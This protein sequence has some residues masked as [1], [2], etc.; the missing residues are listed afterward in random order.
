MTLAGFRPGSR[1][2]FLSGKGLGVFQGVGASLAIM[3][4]LNRDHL[5]WSG[6][7]VSH[8]CFPG[9]GWL[10]SKKGIGAFLISFCA[11]SRLGITNNNHLDTKIG[12]TS[13]TRSTYQRVLNGKTREWIPDN[14]CREYRMIHDVSCSLPS[15]SILAISYPCCTVHK[16]LLFFKDGRKPKNLI[17]VVQGGAAKE[18]RAKP[19]NKL[20]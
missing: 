16:K 7:G 19:K 18:Q 9:Q 3:H 1:V 20:T 14:N 12:S 8:V 6:H 4:F 5:S 13:A 11:G 17:G 10:V 15:S 2:T